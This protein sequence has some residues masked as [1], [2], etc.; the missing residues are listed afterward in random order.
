MFPLLISI[1]SDFSHPVLI[2]GGMNL[3]AMLGLAI[4]VAEVIRAGE[5]VTLEFL[6]AA[7]APGRGDL[8]G[9]RLLALRLAAQHVSGVHGRSEPPSIRSPPSRMRERTRRR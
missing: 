3:A 8:V 6:E 5:P 9:R 7:I 2:R 4:D 1:D